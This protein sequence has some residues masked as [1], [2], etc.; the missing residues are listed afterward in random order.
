M[1]NPMT[2]LASSLATLAPGQW[3]AE[4]AWTWYQEQPWL[5]GCKLL[6]RTAHRRQDNN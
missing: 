2:L 4:R 3:T 5:V 1:K 6:P